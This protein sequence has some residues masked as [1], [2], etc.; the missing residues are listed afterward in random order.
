MMMIVLRLKKLEVEV[1][2]IN[3]GDLSTAC[4]LKKTGTLLTNHYEVG[5]VNT[6]VE[7]PFSVGT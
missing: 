5:Y 6:C 3:N 2:A 1:K 4:S 7:I